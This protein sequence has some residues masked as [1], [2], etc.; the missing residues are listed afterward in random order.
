[1]ADVKSPDGPS[2]SN[3]PVPNDSQEVNG[4]GT[5]SNKRKRVGGNSARGVANLTPQQLERKRANDREAQRAIRERTK[6]QIDRLN[7][8]IRELESAQPYRD[9]QAVITQKEAVEAENVEIKRQLA[10]FINIFRSYIPGGQGLEG[11][12]LSYKL[13]STF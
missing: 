6:Q 7:D 1:M 4:N 3:S 12:L 10:Q 5:G 2:A 11:A 9:L 13:P 8:K